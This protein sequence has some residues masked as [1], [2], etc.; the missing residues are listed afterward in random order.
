VLLAK[1]LDLANTDMLTGCL[2]HGGFFERLDIEIDRAMRH[3]QPLS[4]LIADVDLFKAF[5][6]AMDTRRETR[7]CD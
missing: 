2:N 4:L 3:G 7:L 1:A 5:N 6:D